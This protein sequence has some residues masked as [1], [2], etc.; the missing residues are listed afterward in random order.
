MIPAKRSLQGGKYVTIPEAFGVAYRVEE[1][2]SLT[3]LWKVSGWYSFEVFL[4][5]DGQYL[6]RMGS[7]NVGHE[8]E[9]ND[10]AVAFYKKGKFLKKYS[11]AELVENKSAV[12]A[13]VSHYMWLARAKSI[14]D[15]E[16]KSDP[17]AELKLDWENIFHLKT[18]DGILYEF[19]A[20]TGNIKKK[21]SPNQPDAGDGK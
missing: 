1:D 18:I 5:D 17:E 6:V 16:E 20:I 3:E 7:W 8:P 21:R 2:G 13:S 12:I 10:L 14:F 4:S 11:T 9:E 15:N 19:D